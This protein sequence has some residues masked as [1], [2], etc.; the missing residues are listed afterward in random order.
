MEF[1]PE[2][3][4]SREDLPLGIAVCVEKSSIIMDENYLKEY[5]IGS[6]RFPYDWAVL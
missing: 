1:Y 2:P 3:L 6:D 5:K 4:F